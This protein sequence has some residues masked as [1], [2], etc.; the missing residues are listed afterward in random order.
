MK[1]I[2]N[3]D[4]N[5]NNNNNNKEVGIKIRGQVKIVVWET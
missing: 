1:I 3:V 2:K 5:E 4:E